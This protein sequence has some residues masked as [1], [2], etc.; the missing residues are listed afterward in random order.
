MRIQDPILRN[1]AHALS[2]SVFIAFKGTNFYIFIYYMVGANICS[3]V[4]ILVFLSTAASML[5]I[6]LKLSENMPEIFLSRT[7]LRQRFYQYQNHLLLVAYLSPFIC[8]A[9]HILVHC[10]KN[11]NIPK[12]FVQFS[13]QLKI[14]RCDG[15]W[16]YIIYSS[17]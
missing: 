13:I 8:G 11:S 9:F 1:M 5:R 7:Q 10:K 4:C 15:D 16:Q 14:T 6:R 17:S 12:Y 3:I 2:L